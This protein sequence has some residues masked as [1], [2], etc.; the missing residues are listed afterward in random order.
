MYVL[1]YW[2]DSASLIVRLVLEELG[3]PFQARR[4]DRAAGELDSPAYR[5]LH[6]LGKIPVLET[7]DGPMFETAAILLYLSERH[8]A[9]APLPGTPDRAAFL[10]WLCFT[11]FNLHATLLEVFY[12]DRVAGPQAAAQVLAH[13]GPRVKGFLQVLERMV[14]REAPAFLSSAPSVLGYYLA[15]QMRWLAQLPPGSPGHVASTDYPALHAVLAAL[16]SRPAAQ[17]A[18]RAEALGPT[19]FTL[20]ET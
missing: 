3:V 17:R 18:A 14:A 5:A 4:I 20:A 7:P 13:A 1:H 10:K 12:P 2:P 9:L 15:V 6:P 19:L 11:S 8:A 16:E